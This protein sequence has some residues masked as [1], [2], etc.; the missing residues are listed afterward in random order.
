[1]RSPGTSE[2]IGETHERN[3]EQSVFQSKFGPDSCRIQIRS[4][5]T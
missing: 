5:A 3:L 1:M 4:V 2:G